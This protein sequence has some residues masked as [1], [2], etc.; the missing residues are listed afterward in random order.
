MLVAAAITVVGLLAGIVAAQLRGLRLGGVIV[1]P[2]LAVYCLRSFAT[3][4][5]VLTSAVGAYAALAIVKRRHFVYGRRL[6]VLSVL[7]GAVVPVLILEFV[8]LWTGR[9]VPLTEA[10][11]LGSILPGIAAYNVHRLDAGRRIE[12]ALWSLAT[13]LFLVVAGTGLLGVLWLSP[14][15]ETLPPVLLG[16]ESDVARSLGIALD[17]PTASE[18]GSVEIVLGLVTVGVIVSEAVRKR[19]ALRVGGVIV[20]PL[21]ALF[22]LREAS[23]LALAG[24]AATTAYLGVQ[25]VHRWALVYGRVL[26]SMSQIVSLLTTVAVVPF[27]DVATGLL[28]FFTAVLAG[29]AAYH[30]HVTPPVERRATVLV[31][32]ATLCAFLWLASAFVTPLQG[33]LM[34]STGVVHVVVSLTVGVLAARELLVLETIRPAGTERFPVF[35]GTESG[36][37]SPGR[38]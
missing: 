13:L 14:F 38:D 20:V 36:T 32:A 6:F 27:L 30:L 3:F 24:F 21:L 11:F 22:A 37:G 29:V 2:L 33:G 15:R 19:Y 34:R 8:A 25:L 26:L 4:V 9:T 5:V 35:P 23:L 16:P 1:V 17:A 12:D 31:T 10:D 7:V 28:P 18:L